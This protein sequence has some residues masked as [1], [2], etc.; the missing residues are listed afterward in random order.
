MKQKKIFPL[1]GMTAASLVIAIVAGILLLT[2]AYALPTARMRYHVSLNLPYLEQD[3]DYY[4]WAP[5]HQSTA[6]DGFTDAIML[7][8]AIYNSATP[9]F[10]MH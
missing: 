10:V 2:C 1:F 7:G 5:Y 3:G 6:S 9:P 8:N 4:F